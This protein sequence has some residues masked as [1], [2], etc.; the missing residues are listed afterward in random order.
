MAQFLTGHKGPE[1]L[2]R[3]AKQL[4][5]GAVRDKG[6]EDHQND[7]LKSVYECPWVRLGHF[8]VLTRF[9]FLQGHGTFVW[10]FA[11]G[12]TEGQKL[13][14]FA[15]SK[16][17]TSKWV[18]DGAE[19]VWKEDNLTGVVLVGVNADVTFYY[20]AR[21]EFLALDKDRLSYK[22]GSEELERWSKAWD[23]LIFQ[24]TFGSMMGGGE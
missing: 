5:V 22:L 9:S 17:R 15:S 14:G 18:G 21:D 13:G 4:V 16:G 24:Q 23:E 12:V 10:D 6:F 20:I 3:F 2:N 7:D 1:S 19:K 11:G 8:N